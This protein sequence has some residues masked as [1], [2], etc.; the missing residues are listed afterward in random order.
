[1]L[2]GFKCDPKPNAIKHFTYHYRTTSILLFYKA[3]LFI[4]KSY[5]KFKSKM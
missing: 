3:I 1:M 2:I 5:L 4:L